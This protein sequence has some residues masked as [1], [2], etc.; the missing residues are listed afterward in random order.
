MEKVLS[1][2]GGRLV[3]I[4]STL[5][6]LPVYL[7][8]C[9]IVPITVVEEIEKIIKRFLWGTGDGKKKFISYLLKEFVYPLSL[10]VWV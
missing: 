9:R 7:L 3:L 5:Q 6:N 8:S 2:K 1:L 10:G 4:K